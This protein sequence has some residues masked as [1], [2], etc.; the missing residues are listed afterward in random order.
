MELPVASRRLV[1]NALRYKFVGEATDWTS[2]RYSQEQC[3]LKVCLSTC[4]V[5]SYIY[6]SYNTMYCMFRVLYRP[7]HSQLAS[8]LPFL[9]GFNQ[10]SPSGI[11]TDRPKWPDPSVWNCDAISPPPP[12]YLLSLRLKTL[13]K[14]R[15]V[16]TRWCMGYL[17]QCFQLHGGETSNWGTVSFIR[18]LWLIKAYLH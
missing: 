8:R 16:T 15:G 10:R 13:K 5:L 4:P 1:T 18:P 17:L 12:P 14:Q 2:R 9:S 7:A 6:Y 3:V 11:N